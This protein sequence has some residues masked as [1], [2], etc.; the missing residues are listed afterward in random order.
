M[1]I[2]R[3]KI[4]EAAIVILNRDGIGGLSMRVLAREL[5]I[6]ASSLY[7]HIKSKRDLYDIVAEKISSGMKIACSMKDARGYLVQTA[8]LYREKLLK[9]R[10]S[11]EIFTQSAPVTPERLEIIKN[12]IV[13]L[14]H[15]GVGEKDCVIASNMFN[16][17][18][19]AFVADEM[20]W[21]SFANTENP[22][23]SIL[24]VNLEIM[25]GDEQFL[26]G[27]DVLFEG[28]KILK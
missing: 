6:K 9:V 27:L 23:S 12:C 19:L 17:Y 13:C 2:T 8:A 25:S 18:V 1:E 28:F 3:D 16:N 20:R 15:L 24:G 4:A 11:V 5:N 26:R 14:L 21:A 10:D 22:F 7:W